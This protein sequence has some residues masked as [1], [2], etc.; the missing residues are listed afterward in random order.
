MVEFRRMQMSDLN[1]DLQKELSKLLQSARARQI[2][3][4]NEVAEIPP[5]PEPC[6]TDMINEIERLFTHGKTPPL[7]AIAREIPRIILKQGL[8]LKESD[9][10]AMDSVQ[11]LH[12]IITVISQNFSPDFLPSCSRNAAQNFIE[13]LGLNKIVKQ[14]PE[15][16]ESIVGAFKEDMNVNPNPNSKL[17]PITE[18]SP[19]AI[20]TRSDS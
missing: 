16:L 15:V 5:L 1:A 13:I 19:E 14:I 2:V 11:I 3:I 6:V 12:A 4:G 20:P 8:G 9:I 10:N 18:Q 17:N 7:R